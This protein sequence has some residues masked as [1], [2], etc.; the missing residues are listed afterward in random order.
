VGV[1][2]GQDGEREGDVRGRRDGPAAQRVALT[3]REAN[4]HGI[5]DRRDGDAAQGGGD[6]QGRPGAVGQVPG[7]ELALELDA[8]DEEEDREEAVGGPLAEGEVE[9]QGER[10]AAEVAQGLVCRAPG[11]VRPDQ[12][13]HGGAEEEGAANG[14][15]AQRRGDVLRFRPASAAE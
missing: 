15:G 11:S 5:Q 6:G 14:L 10:S 12:S 8:R 1:D 13:E 7:D 4:G 2:H 9:V 3:P